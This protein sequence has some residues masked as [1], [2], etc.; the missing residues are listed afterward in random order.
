MEFRT[1][2]ER[3][4]LDMVRV[5]FYIILRSKLKSDNNNNNNNNVSSTSNTN[6]STINSNT[7]RGGDFKEDVIITKDNQS[8]LARFDE[9]WTFV[10]GMFIYLYIYILYNLYLSISII[11]LLYILLIKI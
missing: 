6:N 1:N 10:E 3:R 11:Y 5:A 9:N 8:N 7:P 2:G 4:W